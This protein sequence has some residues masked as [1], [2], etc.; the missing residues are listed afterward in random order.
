RR[1]VERH[2]EQSAPESEGAASPGMF[3]LLGEGVG[4]DDDRASLPEEEL[5]AEEEAQIEAA[6]QATIG[7]VKAVSAKLLFEKERK[8]L[9]QMA[10]IAEKARSLPDARIRALVDWIRMHM[11]PD[12]PP[13]GKQATTSAKW[14]DTRF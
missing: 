3:D 14:N 12:L 13:L 6:S 1:T 9:D 8:L 2:L 10:E 5:Q 11:C 4:S 7:P